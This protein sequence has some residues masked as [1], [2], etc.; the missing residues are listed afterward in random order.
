LLDRTSEESGRDRILHVARDMFIERGFTDVSMQQ[1]ADAAGLRKASIYHHFPSKVDLFVAVTWL[2]IDDLYRQTE[3]A[4]AAGD[5]LIPQLRAVARV[6]FASIRG[7]GGRLARDFQEHVPG[8]EHGQFEQRLGLFIETIAGA[9]EGAARRGQ[10]R[11]IDPRIAAAVFF[12]IVS[13]WVY[14]AYL[15][16]SAAPVDPDAAVET[17]IDLLLFGIATPEFARAQATLAGN[18]TPLPLPPDQVAL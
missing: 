6:W 5:D 11:D 10:I 4:M 13:G 14:R 17:I 2:E 18:I 9:F 7:D 15:D 8:S 3:S 16:P 12:D 1:I